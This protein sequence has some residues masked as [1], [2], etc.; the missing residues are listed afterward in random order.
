MDGYEKLLID[1]DESLSKLNKQTREE[2]ELQ[3]EYVLKSNLLLDFNIKPRDILEIITPTDLEKFC[4]DVSKELPGSPFLSD[5]IIANI[6]EPV[7]VILAGL[8]TAKCDVAFMGG[9]GHGTIE[10]ACIDSFSKRVVR[11]SKKPVL[12]ISLPEGK[13]A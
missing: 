13:S 4:K 11:Q 7:D 12:V 5:E 10:E 6:R 1:L 3:D 9:H 8:K 2:F